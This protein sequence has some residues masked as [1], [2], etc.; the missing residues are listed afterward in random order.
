MLAREVKHGRL[1]TIAQNIALDVQDSTTH[2]FYFGKC[3]DCKTIT[4]DSEKLY[5]NG[6]FLN[7]NATVEKVCPNKRIAVGLALYETTSGERVIKDHK[8]FVV[9][10]SESCCADITLTNVHFILPEEIAETSD[11]TTICNRRNF[12][13]DIASHYIDLTCTEE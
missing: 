7:L 5:G 6:K 10:H 11:N 8:T 9:S 3:K 13:L 1:K 12:E 4:L 2:E